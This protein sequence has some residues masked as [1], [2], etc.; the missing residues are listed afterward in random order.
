[1]IEQVADTGFVGV[2]GI[3]NDRLVNEVSIQRFLA[4]II[5]SQT[6]K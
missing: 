4:A 2:V 1:M 5:I 3:A 6:K